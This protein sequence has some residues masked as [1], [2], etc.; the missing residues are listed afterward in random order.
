MLSFLHSILSDSALSLKISENICE[1][2]H[3][4]QLLREKEIEEKQY[5]VLA[6]GRKRKMVFV[7]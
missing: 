3:L 6:V 7:S 4:A 1:K 2:L 5:K